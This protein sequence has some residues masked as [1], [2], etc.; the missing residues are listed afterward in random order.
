M[1][2]TIDLKSAYHQI[3]LDPRDREFT[4]FQSGS[5]LYQWWRLPFGLTN[6]VPEFQRAIN[7]FVAQNKLK[8]CFPYLDDITIAGIDQADHDRNLKAFYD[9]AAKWKLTL[10]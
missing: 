9:A 3:E 2:T 4:A 7:S 8:C 10:N 5:D 1:F 6:A